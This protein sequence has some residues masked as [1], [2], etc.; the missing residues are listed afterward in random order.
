[1]TA[2]ARKISA[3]EARIAELERVPTKRLLVVSYGVGLDSTAVLVGL[4]K[5]GIRPDLILFADTGGE[6][7]ETMAFIPIVNEWLLRV[8][9]PTVTVVRFA[10]TTAPY[11]TLEG[12]CLANE[13]LPSLAMGQHQCALVF[14]RDVMVKF[15]KT[16]A[17]AVEAIARG[18]KIDQA[19]GYD[20]GKRDRQRSAKADKTIDRLR[21]VSTDKY[22]S[23]TDRAAR[24]LAPLASQWQVANCRNVYFLQEWELA[25]EDL[26]ETIT[27]AGLAV[28]PKSSC[29]FCP[30]N[31]IA[32]VVALRDE[33]PDL[34]AR[35]LKIERTA[36]FGKHAKPGNKVGLGM[37][38]W[39]WAW[40]ANARDAAHGEELV[41][42]HGVKVR[43][44]VRP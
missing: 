24:G 39:S 8:G 25:R 20:N 4:W 9:F 37:G 11:T 18:E 36:E 44:G 35:A 3:L 38:N 23:V 28:P 31:S 10:P 6:K 1:M 2:T 22:E 7:P 29:W 41:R 12:K 17:P 16:W 13:V 21:N 19:I 40:L 43:A 32:E 33:H 30:A 42:A 14:K 26:A 15:L 5:R 27:A 34:Y